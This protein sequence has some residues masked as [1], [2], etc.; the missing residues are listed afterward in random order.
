MND[1]GLVLQC[2]GS[3]R[4]APAS[5]VVEDDSCYLKELGIYSKVQL[6]SSRSTQTTLSTGDLVN[7]FTEF[8]RIPETGFHCQLENAVR[9]ESV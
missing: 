5:P 4:D 3:G 6:A 2:Q 7:D 8:P 9:S 1:T